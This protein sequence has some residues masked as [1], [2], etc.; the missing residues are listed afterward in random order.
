MTAAELIAKAHRT[1]DT[2]RHLS[3]ESPLAPLLL[4]RYNAITAQLGYDPLA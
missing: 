3:P 1:A 2:Y 4:R